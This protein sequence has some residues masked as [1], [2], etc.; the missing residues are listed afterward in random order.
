[1]TQTGPYDLGSRIHCKNV[2]RKLCTFRKTFLLTFITISS[3][4]KM[5]S[6]NTVECSTVGRYKGKLMLMEASGLA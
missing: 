2:S 4:Y 3:T 5:K 6:N 1:M